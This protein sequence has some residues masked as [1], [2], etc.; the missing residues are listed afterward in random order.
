MVALKRA[1]YLE[2][3]YLVTALVTSETACLANS[4]DRRRRTAVWI[5]RGDSLGG[6]VTKEFMM[7]MALED[8]PVSGCTCFNTS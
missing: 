8:T 7:D 3:A 2:L 6:D 1:D 4:P 5:S